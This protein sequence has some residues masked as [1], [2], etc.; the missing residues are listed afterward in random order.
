MGAKWG[1]I[2]IHEGKRWELGNERKVYFLWPKDIVGSK[3]GG[4][5]PCVGKK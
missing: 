2:Y 1:W 5:F 3:Q 4:G